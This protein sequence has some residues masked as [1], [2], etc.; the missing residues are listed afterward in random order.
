MY[1]VETLIVTYFSVIQEEVSV[2][3][4]A[5]CWHVLIHICAVYQY[6]S[7]VNN[8]RGTSAR[9]RNPSIFRWT[10]L[11]S[12]YFLRSVKTGSKNIAVL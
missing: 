1:D 12:W 6:V 9:P 4:L 3:D 5:Y 7:I 2:T 8:F 10:L 11:F